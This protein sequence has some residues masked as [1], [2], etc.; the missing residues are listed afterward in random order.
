MKFILIIIISILITA[1][2]S[3]NLK[4][5]FEAAGGYVIGKENCKTDTTQD[6]WLIDFSIYP[7]ANNYGA[8]IIFNGITY[9]N[10]VKTIGLAPQ[11]KVI[12]SRVGF[13][14]HLASSSI[15]TLNCAVAN[16]ITFDLKEM[17]ILR[18]AEIR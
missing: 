10:V 4:P 15:Q 18:Q 1:C 9:K 12:G 11:F 17:Q 3:R 13:D 8:T 14:F 6:Y 5:N 16:P 7:L 2:N